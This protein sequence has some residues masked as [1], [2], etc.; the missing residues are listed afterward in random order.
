LVAPD[1]VALVTSAAGL[2]LAALLT[3]A[4]QAAITYRRGSTVAL[5]I[6]E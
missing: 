6:T 4:A 2:I 1:P 5:R 3:L